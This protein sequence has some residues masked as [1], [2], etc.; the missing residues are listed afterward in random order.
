M[1]K[2]ITL[3][4]SLAYIS[5]SAQYE[6][7]ADLNE[8]PEDSDCYCNFTFTYN[9]DCAVYLDNETILFKTRTEETDW[10]LYKITSAGVELVKDIY[11]GPEDS[12]IAYMTL[13]NEKVYFF[14][15]DGNG[16]RIWES[17]GTEAGTK[18][19]IELGDSEE[20]LFNFTGFIVNQDKLYFRYKSSIF[21]YD[22]DNLIELAHD[23]AIAI[24]KSSNY[25]SHAWCRYEDGIALMDYNSDKWELLKFSES[26][27][28]KLADYQAENTFINPNG[29]AEFD[30]NLI[31]SFDAS[32]DEEVEGMYIFKK[33]DSSFTKY[34]DAPGSRIISIN[35][36]N[37]VVNLDGEFLHFN[38]ANPDG[39]LIYEGSAIGVQGEDWKREVIGNELIFRSKV[40]FFAD[41]EL[42]VYDVLS[43]QVSVEYDGD[44]ISDLHPYAGH[45]L[46]MAETLGTFSD[47]SVYGYDSWE[48]ETTDRVQFG[49]PESFN[50]DFK[51]IG[52]LDEELYFFAELDRDLGTE[53][54]KTGIG[55]NVN[56]S[57]IGDSEYELLDLGNGN[58]VIYSDQARDIIV[59]VFDL[60]GRKTIELNTSIGLP[61][62]L[63]L[64]GMY[65]LTLANSDNYYEKILI[66]G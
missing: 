53:I 52:V 30:G 50:V 6:L 25:N 55:L 63:P 51:P 4:F 20:S 19:A 49:E 22:G 14:A 15:N 54:Y 8:G 21:L 62:H 60:S 9:Q 39:K 11:P 36:D 38:A 13:F 24:D 42:L 65:V 32:F 45:V 48:N 16:T 43:E 10:E 46:F 34:D 29:M 1:N 58:Y 3:I 28:E 5:L 64:N 66:R 47:Y 2:L 35:A 18:I 56:T 44:N 59:Q 57:E 40:D 37:C 31:V 61:F 41:D 12:D 33:A 27:S 23:D 17:D 26:G 7:V